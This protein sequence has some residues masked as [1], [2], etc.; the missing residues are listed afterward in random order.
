MKIECEIVKDL[1]PS[2][3]ENLVS[4]QTRKYVVNHISNCSE[5]R[6]ILQSMQTNT[7]LV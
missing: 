5:C 7:I 6:E 1:L 3:V 2:Y 4:E